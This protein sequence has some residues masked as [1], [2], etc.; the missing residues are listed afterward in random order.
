[1]DRTKR[2]RLVAATVTILLIA[3]AACSSDVIT[4]TSVDDPIDQTDQATS[5]PAAPTPEPVATSVIPTPVATP[6]SHPWYECDAVQTAIPSDYRVTNIPADDPDG[7][8]VA[9]VA[10]GVD[11]TVTEVLPDGTDELDITGCQQNL[12][13]DAVWWLVDERGWVNARYLEA[14]VPG[15]PDD[16][17]PGLSD[18]I[19]AEQ[20]AALIGLEAPDLDTLETEIGLA[21]GFEDST[22]TRIG[23]FTGV[24]A[25][26]GFAAST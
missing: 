1:M 3:L 23:E 17:Q 4:A 2:A 19:D 24:D 9:H 14:H 7:G 6:P 10:P 26:G 5:A 11:A 15:G 20:F 8:L 18:L 22:V 21:L 25:R 16:W 12:N 13:I